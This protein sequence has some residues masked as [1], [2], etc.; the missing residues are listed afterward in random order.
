MQTQGTFCDTL[1]IR[2]H[3]TFEPGIYIFKRGLTMNNNNYSITGTNVLFYLTC[4]DVTSI[5]KECCPPSEPLCSGNDDRVDAFE[6][7]GG[8]INVSAPAG[9][10]HIVIWVDRTS[11]EP[12]PAVKSFVYL[13]GNGGMNIAGHIYSWPGRVSVGGT[14]DGSNRTFDGTIL[15]DKVEFSGN[16]T[17]NINFNQDLA[18]KFFLPSL[19]E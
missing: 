14:S 3:V 13:I 17:Y 5:T 7:N 16:A 18:P 10:P 9:D 1:D 2:D 11:V 15:G 19:I 4:R 6:M 12:Q 8:S